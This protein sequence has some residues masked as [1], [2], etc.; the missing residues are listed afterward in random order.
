MILLSGSA[1]KPLAENIAL[2]LNISVS[3]LEIHV[4][5]D[6]ERRVRVEK[7]V[8]DQDVVVVQPTSM[9]VDI[10]IWSCFL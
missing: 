8:V 5:P 3:P 9:P 4:F 7:N 6:G 10:I 2:Q 1:N